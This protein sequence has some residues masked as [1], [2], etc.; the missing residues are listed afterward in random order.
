MMSPPVHPA[1]AALTAAIQ[2]LAGLIRV[3]IE[4][5][6][7]LSL[8]AA[9]W[10]DSC[11]GV[12]ARDEACADVVTPGYIIR[13]ADGFEYHADQLGNVRRRPGQHPHPDTEIRLRY[14]ISGGITGRTTTFETDS[15]RLSQAEDD[16]LRWL[17]GEADFFNVLNPPL[18]P[19]I[20]D[21]RVETLWIAVGRRYHEVVRGDG[22]VMH[23]TDAFRALAA[24][25]ARRTPSFPEPAVDLG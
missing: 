20:P 1:V 6:Q 14:T 5:I 4:S 3:P 17:I 10:P 21:G 22:I 23:D 16:E 13:L 8:E 25:A 12:P 24:W 19:A 15:Y 18:G 9:D 7:V 2:D 11:L